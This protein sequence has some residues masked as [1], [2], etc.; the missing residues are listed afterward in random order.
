MR[1]MAGAVALAAAAVAFALACNGGEPA[2]PAT[3]PTGTVTP[4]ARPATSPGRTV[5]PTATATA[6]PT[7][8]ASPSPTP[9]P[10]S[11]PQP[12]TQTTTPAA[13]TP[14]P[15][16]VPGGYELEPA[17]PAATFERMVGLSPIPGSADEAVVISQGGLVWRLPL[18]GGPASVFGDLRGLLISNPGGEEG[19]LGL[20]F[21]PDFQSDG[22]VYVHYTAG[23]PRRSLLSRFQVVNGAMEMT[24]ERVLLE[25][26]QPFGNHNGGQIAFGPDGYLYVALGD[27]GGAGDPLGSGQ[28][29]SSLLGSIL[30][31]DV[32]GDDYSVPPDNPFL[33]S[34]GA[35]AEI[36]AYGLRNPWRFSFDRATGDLWA[37][38]VGQ[39]RWEEVD[40]IVAGGNYGW[41]ILEGFECFQSEDCDTTGLR[42]PRAVYGHDE[43]CSVTGG[44]VYRGPSLPELAGWYI[45]G[46]FCSGRVWALDTAE[47][48][49]PVLLAETGLPISSFGELRDG[50]LVVVTF[51]DAIFQLRRRP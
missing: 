15:T 18:S 4:T 30:R 29:L 40:R 19:L 41:N 43:G 21:S 7:A 39:S 28:D 2:A 12:P 49:L 10:A 9:S 8:I 45:Y 13:A 47:D 46:D 5:T 48:S 27:G 44:F 37:A 23:S 6:T 24:S 34:G 20:A 16:P 1:G 17:V 32:S 3:S 38:D 11:T 25:V 35:R 51:A 14:V 33:A 26:A 22:R 36:Y 42:L 50:E 31:L